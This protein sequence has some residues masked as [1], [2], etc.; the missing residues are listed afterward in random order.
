[1]AKNIATI[2]ASDLEALIKSDPSLLAKADSEFCANEYLSHK[3]EKPGA[4]AE[5]T[6]GKQV[7]AGEELTTGKGSR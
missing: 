2:Y 5:N 3:P 1:M 4:T 7:G 6:S